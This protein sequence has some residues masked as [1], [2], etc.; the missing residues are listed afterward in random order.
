MIHINI[1]NVG[2]CLM[3]IGFIHWILPD[4]Y[5]YELGAI[6]GYIIK[7][8]WIIFCIVYFGVLGHSVSIN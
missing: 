4:D 7:A 1:I 8:V 3:G 2:V 6:R 5:K